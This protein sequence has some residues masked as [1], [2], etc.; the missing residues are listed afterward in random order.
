VASANGLNRGGK[1]AGAVG[2][3]LVGQDALN[4]HAA[5][6][7]NRRRG[8]QEGGG[9]LLGLVGLPLNHRIT[10]RV[11]DRHVEVVIASPPV[12]PVAMRPA[13]RPPQHAMTTAVWNSAQLLGVEVEQLAGP[14]PDI[15]ER[16]GRDPVRI[17][18][19]TEVVAPK[20]PID[21]GSANAERGRQPMRPLLELS[22]RLQDSRQL[23]CRQR[24]AATVR[25]RRPV[26]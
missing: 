21:G 15:T 11:I 5:L 16:D 20:H 13:R 19:A 18:E 23:V 9:T 25:P 2:A 10:R 22:S 8:Q 17:A 1:G 6:G 4:A 3:A 12:T 7:K 24:M 26:R 14:L